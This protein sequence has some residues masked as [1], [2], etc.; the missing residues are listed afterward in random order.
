MFSTELFKSANKDKL[1]VNYIQGDTLATQ[2]NHT[3][4][5]LCPPSTSDFLLL[6]SQEWANY[7]FC[8]SRNEIWV[9]EFKSKFNLTDYRVIE[10][11]IGN[12]QKE[13]ENM[14]GKKSKSYINQWY[15]NELQ[16]Y[17]NNKTN[18]KLFKVRI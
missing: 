6:M 9:I 2:H 15:G 17:I 11:D 3:N 4:K 12:I 5:G 1:Q 14:K 16:K 13:A 7:S 10:R 18:I 8:I